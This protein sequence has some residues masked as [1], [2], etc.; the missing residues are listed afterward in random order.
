MN[1]N[2]ERGLIQLIATDRIEI[3]VSSMSGKLKKQKPTIAYEVA[4]GFN[5]RYDGDRTY[6]RI[7]E[8][9][10]MKARGTKEAIQEFKEQYPKYGEIL[11]GKIDEKRSEREV[12][13]YFGMKEG[14]RITEADYLGVMSDLGFTPAMARD[15]YPALMDVSRKISRKRNEERS[16]LIG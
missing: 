8:S 2:I 14:S 4:E 5:K 10:K 15:L 16:I 11:Q 9:D 7:E 13:L 3:P 12:H 1:E 6:A